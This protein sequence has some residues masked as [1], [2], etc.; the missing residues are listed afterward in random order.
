[1]TEQEYAD[2]G[3]YLI[4]HLTKLMSG[5]HRGLSVIC[6]IRTPDGVGICRVQIDMPTIS[7]SRLKF[8]KNA[9]PYTEFLRYTW[10]PDSKG[11]ILNDYVY[12]EK[13]K[14]SKKK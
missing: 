13:I 10:V 5:E 8:D 1:M 6:P 7:D 14:K 11:Y 2:L 12:K 3:K 9:R 4:D